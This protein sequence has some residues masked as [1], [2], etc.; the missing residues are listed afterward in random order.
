MKYKVELDFQ[1][2]RFYSF[3]LLAIAVSLVIAIYSYNGVN[4]YV[5]RRLY[6]LFLTFTFLFLLSFIM[7]NLT[8]LE[9]R[10]KLKD[11]YKLFGAFSRERRGRPR[12]K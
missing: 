12:K 2:L 10:K 1:V 5:T 9:L 7:F 4:V 11:E 6:E 8:Y 3:T